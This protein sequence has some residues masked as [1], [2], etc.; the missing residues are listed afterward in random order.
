MTDLGAASLVAAS[1]SPDFWQPDVQNKSADVR[2]DREQI[3]RGF[4]E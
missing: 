4:L 3:R 1:R 2:R